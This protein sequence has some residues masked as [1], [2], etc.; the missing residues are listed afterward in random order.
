MEHALEMRIMPASTRTFPPS[1]GFPARA[2]VVETLRARIVFEPEYR[3][4]DA[5]RGWEGLFFPSL[6]DLAV[7]P[8]GAGALVS[9]GAAAPAEAMQMGVFA[10]RSPFRPNAIG[11][12]AVKLEGWSSTPRRDL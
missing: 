12:S 5:L 1:L 9:H 2:G 3:N 7:F 8:G 10:T 4:P 11:L 6:A